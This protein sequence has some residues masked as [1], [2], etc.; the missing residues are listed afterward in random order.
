MPSTQRKWFTLVGVV[1]TGLTIFGIVAAATDSNP[2]D[3]P[4]DPLALNGY[5]PKTAE[6]SVAITTGNS[7]MVH[8]IVDVNFQTNKIEAN[9]EV[10]LLL[11]GVPVDIRVLGDEAY[12]NTPNFTAT[13]GK[14]WIRLKEKLPSLFNYS[15]EF[16]RPDIALISGFPRETITKSGYF[17]THDFSRDNVALKELGA[18]STT[19]PKVGSLN[20]SITTGKQ[21]EV[22]Q[23][24]VTVRRKHQ[25]TTIRVT[26]VAYN[27]RT[28]IVRPQADEVKAES[29]LYLKDLL[30]S[31]ALSIL[32]PANLSNLGTTSLS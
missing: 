22:T 31:G 15:L 13:L 8:A 11:S 3:I 32:V 7:I 30:G 24:S 1:A 17:V 29:S 23:S 26:V 21:G 27:Q 16:V 19:L 18:S 20:W 2:A 9:F 14:P 25:S 4:K 12:A 28:H 6:L 5:P 10:P